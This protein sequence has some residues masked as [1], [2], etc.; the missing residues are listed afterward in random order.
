MS[1]KRKTTENTRQY[2]K[3]KINVEENNDD[4]Y[5]NVEEAV[6]ISLVEELRILQE[7][8]KLLQ[9]EN[10]FFRE[11]I[12]YLEQQFSKDGPFFEMCV[13]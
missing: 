13:N 11:Q 5:F 3:Q 10:I 4:L 7:K 1:S 2:K 6:K 8:Y 9:I 12:Q